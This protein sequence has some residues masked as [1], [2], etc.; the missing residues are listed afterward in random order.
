MRD[1]FSIIISITIIFLIT[2]C[3]ELKKSEL[4]KGEISTIKTKEIEFS[5]QPTNYGSKLN[6]QHCY[7][8]ILLK[9]K[10]LSNETI[11]IDWEKTRY[12]SSDINISIFRDAGTKINYQVIQFKKP[13]FIHPNKTSTQNIVPSSQ[14]WLNNNKWMYD[15]LDDNYGI[16]IVYKVGGNTKNIKLTNNP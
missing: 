13:T 14:I 1:I 5:I 8:T 11:E 4:K 12:I 2:G 6:T 10:N 7:S 9:S 16:N 15:C 3:T